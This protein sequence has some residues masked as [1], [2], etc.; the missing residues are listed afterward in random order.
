[1]KSVSR[2]AFV[3]AAL[4]APL[5]LADAN[6]AFAAKKKKKK[7]K[8][9]T[10]EVGQAVAISKKG[11]LNVTVVGCESSDDLDWSYAEGGQTIADENCVIALMLVVDNKSVKTP[12]EGMGFEY[13]LH[14]VDF[15]DVDGISLTPFNSGSD[16]KG[17]GCALSGYFNA[18]K[19]QADRE[20]LFFQVP[21]ETAEIVAVLGKT[22]VTV[23]VQRV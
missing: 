20:V 18:E 22:K 9:L 7:K 1:M 13:Q 5:A 21:R 11:K 12:Y 19:G 15:T 3:T 23:P 6:V 2:R 17:Y 16:Y 14:G 10:A 8:A 4:V